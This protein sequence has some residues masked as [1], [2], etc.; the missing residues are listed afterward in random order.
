MTVCEYRGDM[1]YL[2]SARSREDP[3]TMAAGSMY[4]TVPRM[5]LS[6]STEEGIE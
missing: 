5:V 1:D 3:V 2:G 4:N 6:L